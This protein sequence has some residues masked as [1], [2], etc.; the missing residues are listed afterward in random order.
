MMYFGHL[1][2]LYLDCN[3]GIVLTLPWT[4]DQTPITSISTLT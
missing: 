1:L 2:G 4:I 3:V